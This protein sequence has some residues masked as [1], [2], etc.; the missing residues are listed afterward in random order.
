MFESMISFVMPEHLSAR[1]SNRRSV[2]WAT[3]G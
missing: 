2:R 3:N 1:R